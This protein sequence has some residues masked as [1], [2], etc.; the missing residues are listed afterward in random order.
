MITGEAIAC[1]RRVGRQQVACGERGVHGRRTDVTGGTGRHER[2]M[3]RRAYAARFAC[4]GTLDGRLR[5]NIYCL[6]PKANSTMPA[7]VLLPASAVSRRP[8]GSG[9]K[10]VAR[11]VVG[12]EAQGERRREEVGR[13]VDE[14]IW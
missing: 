11:Y 5:A 10:V 2:L 12:S 3:K 6:P 13:I 14:A 8:P 4:Y 1:L 9:R 7:C